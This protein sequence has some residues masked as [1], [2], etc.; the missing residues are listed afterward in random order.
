MVD[1][2]INVQFHV[3][4]TGIR[5]L[6]TEEFEALERAMDG[7]VKMY[8]LRPVLCRFVIN[9]DGSKMEHAQAMKLVGQIPISMIEQVMRGFTESL[10]VSTVPKE[11]GDLSQPHSVPAVVESP[12]QP[13]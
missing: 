2:K 4:E 7:D 12:S 10:K 5:D 6:T 1:E 3:T 13:G 11:N 9:E 8:R